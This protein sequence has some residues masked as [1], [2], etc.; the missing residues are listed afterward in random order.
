MYLPVIEGYKLTP[1]WEYTWTD[2][3][4]YMRLLTCRNHPTARYLSKNVWTRS[5]FVETPPEGDI[6]R[7]STGEC[8]CSVYDLVV[9]EKEDD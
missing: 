8:T 4:S 3:Y 5:I 9:M 1:A 6:E 2:D 7:T